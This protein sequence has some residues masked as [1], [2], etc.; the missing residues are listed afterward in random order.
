M[1][2]DTWTAA[3]F[4]RR[5]TAMVSDGQQHTTVDIDATMAYAEVEKAATREAYE[6]DWRQFAVWC[7][8]PLPAHQGIVAAYLSHLADTGRKASTI[9][10][11]CAAIAD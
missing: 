8:T 6:S 1:L 2:K 4:F 10:R 11:K 3:H 7:A 5:Q 9:G